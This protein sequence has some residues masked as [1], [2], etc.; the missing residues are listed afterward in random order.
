MNSAKVRITVFVGFVISLNACPVVTIPSIEGT[1]RESGVITSPSELA[2]RIDSFEMRLFGGGTGEIVPGSGF[3]VE[4]PD[5]YE[6][7]SGPSI[8]YTFTG[9]SSTI[10]LNWQFRTGGDEYTAVHVFNL[11]VISA[12][13]LRGTRD[14]NVYSG[15]NLILTAKYRETWTFVSAKDTD[16][17]DASTDPSSQGSEERLPDPFVSLIPLAELWVEA[18]GAIE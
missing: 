17:P 10:L 3:P 12:N 9:S 8:D 4:L 1:W 18:G 14:V 7:V 16:S 5:D 13:E 11:K 15:A 2:G 6:V